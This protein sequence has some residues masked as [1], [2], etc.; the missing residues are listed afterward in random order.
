MKIEID[1]GLL[2]LITERDELVTNTHSVDRFND[3]SAII[4]LRVSAKVANERVF[5]RLISKEMEVS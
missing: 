1:P 4:A 2:K 5:E 3:L